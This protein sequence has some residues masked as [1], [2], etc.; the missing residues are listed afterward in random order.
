[1]AKMLLIDGVAM[2]SPSEFKIGLSDL[3]SNESGK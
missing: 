2:P 1:M 3:D